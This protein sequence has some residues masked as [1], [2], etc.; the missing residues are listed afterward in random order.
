VVYAARNHDKL[1]AH[2][3]NIYAVLCTND[4]DQEKFKVNSATSLGSML[5]SLYT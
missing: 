3:S 5:G 2:K 4:I 1:I